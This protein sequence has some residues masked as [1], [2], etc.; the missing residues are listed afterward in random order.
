MKVLDMNQL[1][2][3]VTTFFIDY[4]PNLNYK[5]KMIDQLNDQLNDSISDVGLEILRL[6]NNNPGINAQTIFKIMT[7]TNEK[8]TIDIVRNS[9]RRELS[10]YVEHRR[11]K[12]TGGYYFKLP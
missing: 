11:S 1:F 9:I 4:L 10:N 8:I 12:K 5:N 6:I 2:T 7:Q 3:I